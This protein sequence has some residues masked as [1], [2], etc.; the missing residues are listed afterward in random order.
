M[1]SYDELPDDPPFS[2]DELPDEPPFW[3]GLQPGYDSEPAKRAAELGLPFST[4]RTKSEP[5]AEPE[6]EL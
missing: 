2:I 4:A 1:P 6:A 3:I 5:E